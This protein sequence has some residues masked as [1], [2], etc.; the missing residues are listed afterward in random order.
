ME[1]TYCVAYTPERVREQVHKN[2]YYRKY[3]VFMPMKSGW[4][5][6]E[7][8]YDILNKRFARVDPSHAGWDSLYDDTFS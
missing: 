8:Y 2:T 6:S 1:E 4:G 5:E 7:F 3:F